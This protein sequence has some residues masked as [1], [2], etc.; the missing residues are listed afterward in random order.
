MQ[1]LLSGTHEDHFLSREHSAQKLRR[2]T[3]VSFG[4]DIKLLVPGGPG[5]KL[6][7]AFSRPLLATIVVNTSGL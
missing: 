4:G 7:P 2:V 3:F 1:A 5:L 6:A